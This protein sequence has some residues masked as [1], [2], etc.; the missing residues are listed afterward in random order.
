[1]VYIGDEKTLN[2]IVRTIF[3]NGGV[4]CLYVYKVMQDSGLGEAIE[5]KGAINKSCSMVGID[6]G[7]VILFFINDST[8]EG[9]D[10]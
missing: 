3:S 5:K 7:W 6:W 10:I 8:R 9:G 4:P 2:V 1:M